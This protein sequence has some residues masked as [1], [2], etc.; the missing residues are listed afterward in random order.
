MLLVLLNCLTESTFPSPS[1]YSNRIQ[2]SYSPNSGEGETQVGG[3]GGGG[4]DPR[5]TPP[6]PP[7]YETLVINRSGFLAQDWH[8]Q[9]RSHSASPE[10]PCMLSVS[11][12]V[13]QILRRSSVGSL[14]IQCILDDQPEI[15]IWHMKLFD[16]ILL[17]LCQVDL[18]LQGGPHYDGTHCNQR[19]SIMNPQANACYPN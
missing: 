3:G 8:W 9:N 18:L 13:V 7:L 6:L 2:P 11:R 4:G 5:A 19:L 16:Y 12:L 17:T 1:S 15:L 10:L 14:K